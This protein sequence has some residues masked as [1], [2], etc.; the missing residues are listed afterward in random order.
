V[1]GTL[2][3][4]SALELVRGFKPQL[5]V[6]DVRM[7]E[8]DG[9]SLMNAL[10]RDD[11]DLQVI[12]MTGSVYDI[13]DQL[14]RAIREKAFYYVTKPFDREVLRAL[15]QRCLELRRLEDQNRRHMQ[16]LEREL[17]T[18][19]ALQQA[20]LPADSARI[21]N[22][23]IRARYRPCVELAGDFYDY[24]A[25][26]QGQV[27]LMVADVVGHGASAAMLTSLVKSA[28]HASQF[29]SYDPLVVVQRV[30]EGIAPF[31]A[32]RFVT[33]LTVRIRANEHVLEYVNAGHDGGLI[34]TPTGAI[35]PLRSTGPIVTAALSGLGWTKE[36]EDWSAHSVLLLYSDGVAERQSAAAMF[37]VERIYAVARDAAGDPGLLDRILEAVDRFAA[38][39]PATDDMTLLM[40]RSD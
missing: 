15:V 16:H 31:D 36:C 4:R 1:L 13:D 27:A 23:D 28:F 6:V 38:G 40:A 14:T 20:M 22:T 17:A 10:K 2:S 11:P 21:E 39:R 33:L 3:S 7:P 12:L 8:M 32:A 26:G 29:E 9:F 35:L 34:V 30:S 18:A 5:A 37:G 19:R 24:A 25:A